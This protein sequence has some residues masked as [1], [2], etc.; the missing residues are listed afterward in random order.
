[1]EFLDGTIKFTSPRGVLGKE[2]A[3]LNENL[4]PLVDFEP[5]HTYAPQATEE[6]FD[7]QQDLSRFHELC[8]AV[9]K[10]KD[11][12][13]N[14]YERNQYPIINEVRW[15]TFGM[16]ILGLY[17]RKLNPNE[18]LVILATF[19][20]QAYGPTHMDII[21]KPELEHATYHVLSYIIRS[22]V[23]TYF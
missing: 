18:V 19:T 3:R 23:C 14:K 13:P 7:E 15:R 4:T 1:M 10:G 8:H 20:T 12:V 2:L 5:I 17:I 16:R 6:F 9:S 22:R 21:V 11:Y